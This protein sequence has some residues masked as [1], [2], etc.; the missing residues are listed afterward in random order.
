MKDRPDFYRGVATGMLAIIAADAFHWFITPAAHPDASGAR[1][2]G[3]AIQAVVCITGAWW[4]A[5]RPRSVEIQEQ[6]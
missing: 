6:A 1:Q 3:V 2:L 5:R 4:L